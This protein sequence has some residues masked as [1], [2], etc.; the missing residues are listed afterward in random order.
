MYS[1]LYLERINPGVQI[2]MPRRPN[3]F[4]KDPEESTHIRV[5]RATYARLLNAGQGLGMGQFD[6]KKRWQGAAVHEILVKL[7]A[8]AGY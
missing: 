1:C 3:I 5:P 8:R 4:K 7:L 2:L 6:E